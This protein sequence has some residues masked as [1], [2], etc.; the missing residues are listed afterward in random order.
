[1]R[2]DSVIQRGLFAGLSAITM[3]PDGLGGCFR[4]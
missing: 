1:L 4:V 2:K 3:K